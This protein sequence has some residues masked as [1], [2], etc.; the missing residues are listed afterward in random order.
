MFSNFFSNIFSFF[1]NLFSDCSKYQDDPSYE[2][3][4]YSQYAEY[5]SHNRI[6]ID[7]LW[8]ERRLLS[9]FHYTPKKKSKFSI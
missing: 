2:R 1:T 3:I 8:Q 4:V 9:F 7:P 5:Y 6:S